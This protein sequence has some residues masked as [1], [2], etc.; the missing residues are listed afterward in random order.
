MAA[1]NA[2]TVRNKARQEAKIVWDRIFEFTKV[3]ADKTEVDR[4]CTGQ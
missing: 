4:G 1:I 2:A 3:K